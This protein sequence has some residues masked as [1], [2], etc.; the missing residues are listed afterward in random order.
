MRKK[1][2]ILE[3]WAVVLPVFIFS[4]ILNFTWESIHSFLL[5]EE[6]NFLAKEYV[7]MV[8]Y[9]SMMDGFLVAGIFLAGCLFWK[10]LHWLSILDKRRIAFILLAGLLVGAFIEY[11]AV[12]LFSQWRYSGAMPVF[13]GVG[14][15]PLFQLSIT[16]LLSIWITRM[17]LYQKGVYYGR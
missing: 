2:K 8:A 17:L 15:S 1:T 11:K 9:A 7:A 3:F 16:A 12:F 4:Y 14:L 6:M 5:Y 13:L 10:N